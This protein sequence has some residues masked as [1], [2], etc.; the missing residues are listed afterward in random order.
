MTVNAAESHASTS[1]HQPHQHQP[2]L[3]AWSTLLLLISTFVTA[4]TVALGVARAVGASG[5]TNPQVMSS[6]IVC[7][8]SWV[9]TLMV[10]LAGCLLTRIDR[11]EERVE[12]TGQQ[13][14]VE[15]A[16][17]LDEYGRRERSEGYTA[18]LINTKVSGTNGHGLHPVR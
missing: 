17:T 6:V 16:S 4:I 3:A 2:N 15:Y 14:R 7:V 1:Q 18:A 13:M 12:D 8:G 10:Y 5:I 9:G 11:V